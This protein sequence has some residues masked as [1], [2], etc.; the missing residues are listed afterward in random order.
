SGQRTLLTGASSGIAR[1]VAIEL[2]AHGSRLA[3]V[4]R[5]QTLLEELAEEIARA[6]HERPQVL[7]A[8]LSER[9]AATE[10]AAQA[11]ERLGS[12]D[13]LINNA[14]GAAGGLQW[15]V[16]DHD[17]A[18][19]ALEVIPG[20]IDTAMQEEQREVPGAED[21]VKRSPLG[22][23]EVLARLVV[24]AL[25]REHRR[26]I[27]PRAVAVGYTF[28]GLFRVYGRLLRRWLTNKI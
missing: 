27:Y 21:V 22:K 7:V 12:V 15:V 11:I 19:G 10:V 13:I 14:G 5:R 3:I 23:P 26:L 2:A 20:V 25:R 6:G 1:A 17:K 24:R 28:P 9:G 8:D 18:R 4:A 16:G